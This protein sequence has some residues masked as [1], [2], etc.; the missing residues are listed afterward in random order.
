MCLMGKVN[1]KLF[2]EAVTVF[3]EENYHRVITPLLRIRSGTG[4]RK[5]HTA[6]SAIKQ[7][8]ER[9]RKMYLKK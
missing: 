2:D 3:I 8:K 7:E 5:K 9:I 1:D 4:S 6:D